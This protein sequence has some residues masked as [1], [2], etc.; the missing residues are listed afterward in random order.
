M[1]RQN[2][3]N[4]CILRTTIWK[5]CWFLYR[6]YRSLTFLWPKLPKCIPLPRLNGRKLAKSI[7]SARLNGLKLAKSIPLARQEGLKKHTLAGGT[8]PGTFT[9]EELPPPR[10]SK[11]SEK[12]V[13]IWTLAP[14]RTSWGSLQRKKNQ[15]RQFQL[16]KTSRQ[17][18]LWLIRYST[19]PWLFVVRFETSLS[20]LQL[21][22]SYTC[23]VFYSNNYSDCR[24]F[25]R[26]YYLV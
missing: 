4:F 15:Y 18:Q 14:R 2:L 26:C 11:T 16:I 13:E 25:G 17:I 12:I 20:H 8:S 9:M 24:E 10:G 6:N 5:K 23:E 19:K 21:N 3:P 7:P 1:S 22:K